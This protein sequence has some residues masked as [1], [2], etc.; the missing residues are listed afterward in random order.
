MCFQK[1]KCILSTLY[2]VRMFKNGLYIVLMLSILQLLC[3]TFLC[4]IKS[5]RVIAKNRLFLRFL[6]VFRY[7]IENIAR[8]N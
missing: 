7:Y 8:S 4:K 1:I 2:Y 3:L 5:R 6:A